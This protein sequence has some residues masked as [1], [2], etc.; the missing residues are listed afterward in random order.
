MMLGTIFVAYQCLQMVILPIVGLYLVLRRFKGKPVFGNVAQRFGLVPRVSSSKKSLWLHAVSVGEIL[1]V[2]QLVADLK[3]KNPDA[4]CY[5]T[6]GTVAGYQMA[7]KFLGADVVSFLPFDFFLPM[8]MAFKRIRPKALMIVEADL[9]PNL[10]MVARWFKIPL[11]LLN[12]RVN[13]RSKKRMK[14]FKWLYAQL[15]NAFEHVFAQSQDDVQA[16]EELGVSATKLSVL[17]NIKA[18][19]VVAKRDQLRPILRQAQDVRATPELCLTHQ[20]GLTAFRPEPPYVLSLSKDKGA[21]V[22]RNHLVLLV[23]SV[24]AGELD[25]YLKLFVTL[26]PLYPSLKLVLAPRHFNW[27]AQLRAST[28][29]TGYASLVWDEHCAQLNNAADPVREIAENILQQYDIVSVCVLGKLFGLYQ[30]A[31]I[32]FLGGTFV[33]VGG[34]NLLEPAVWGK[35]CIV[36]PY[37][38]N[39]QDHADRLEQHQALVKVADYNELEQQVRLLLEHAERRVQAGANAAN[40]LGSEAVMVK[41][42]L[43]QLFKQLN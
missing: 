37:H 34:H 6:T 24:H 2:Q 21:A 14:L 29:A 9:W 4:V 32:F 23:G 1:A 11:Y 19:N 30:L 31:D 36:G 42:N 5:V 38:A 25:H 39:C 41:K 22:V 35:P 15:L 20:D 18:F 26:K 17:G 3:Q 8:V 40:W 7:C 12:A 43:D 27:L 28:A 33:P 10:I 13:P 16:F